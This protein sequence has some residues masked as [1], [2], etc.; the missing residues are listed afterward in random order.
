[1]CLFVRSEK[2]SLLTRRSLQTRLR[3]LAGHPERR[4]VRHPQRAFQRRDEPR[5]LPG[6]QEQVPRQ[7]IQGTSGNATSS[8]G[9]MTSVWFDDVWIRIGNFV[10]GGLRAETLL[11]NLNNV[12]TRT[13]KTS[14]VQLLI[15]ALG[16]H[17]LSMIQITEFVVYKS[18]SY[19][20]DLFQKWSSCSCKYSDRF[21][22][23]AG[24]DEMREQRNI[25]SDL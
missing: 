11:I 17:Y 2:L 14:C 16:I 13:C 15:T 21:P 8:S 23:E 22:L 18:V 6:D 12:Q 5:E 25:K 3:S 19:L 20:S 4:Q 1:M 9:S 10:Y 24:E 7:E